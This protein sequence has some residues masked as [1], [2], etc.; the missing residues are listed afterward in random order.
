[1]QCQYCNRIVEESSNI[2]HFNKKHD[3]SRGRNFDTS[4]EKEIS[5]KD[6]TFTILVS[7][8]GFYACKTCI[9]E[10]KNLHEMYLHDLYNHQLTYEEAKVL[11]RMQKIY[12]DICW[13][14]FEEIEALEKHFE[15]TKH[16]DKQ[17]YVEGTGCDICRIKGR[18]FLPHENTKRHQL[19]LHYEKGSGC[20][21]CAIPK[22][23]LEK[24]YF[25][26]NP[27]STATFDEILKF[28]LANLHHKRHTIVRNYVP[29]SGCDICYSAD[30][31][32]H[33]SKSHQHIEQR[34]LTIKSKTR[35]KSARSV[36]PTNCS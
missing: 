3:L 24:N 1:M 26:S 8:C 5:Y 25:R 13:I 23:E 36:I 18:L 35:A 28:H 32:S 34:M 4:T 15:S 29:G 31:S 21:L 10:T 16:K 17:R 22:C 27:S 9:F 7:P 2:D 33:S 20:D 11:K 12:C 19:Y 30:A 14:E 6:S